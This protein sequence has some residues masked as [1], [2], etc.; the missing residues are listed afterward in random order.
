MALRADCLIS[1]SLGSSSIM[2]PLCPVPCHL[3]VQYLVAFVR[4]RQP[5]SRQRHLQQEQEPRYRITR[6]DTATGN[7]L[8]LFGE[9]RAIL[10]R[11]QKSNDEALS[12]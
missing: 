8:K 5:L 6:L 12:G 1:Y 11:A 4:V 9:R 10:H 2:S 7:W 3:Y